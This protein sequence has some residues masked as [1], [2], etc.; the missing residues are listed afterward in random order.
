M[1]SY[2]SIPYKR[3]NE[4]TRPKDTPSPYEQ[5]QRLLLHY[6]SIHTKAS[7]QS[8]TEVEVLKKNHK[9]IREEFDLGP[10]SSWEDRVAI[11]YYNQLF[12]E[13]CLGDFSRY[14]LKQIGLRWRTK[15]ECVAG[16]G[17]FRCGNIAC[18]I[19]SGLKSWEVLFKYKED[20][21]IKS[22]LVKIRTCEKCTKKLHYKNGK[23]R[24]RKGSDEIEPIRM[25][26]KPKNESKTKEGDVEDVVTRPEASDEELNDS[27]WS[28]PIPEVEE[29]TIEE[30]M[31]SFLAEMFL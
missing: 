24:K 6:S 14:K 15:S 23:D 21:E 11:K 19:A 31:D 29:K 8:Q 13:Y 22:E 28:K 7:T 9:F 30:E 4:V 2:F 26:K 20:G 5:H 1:S 12:K 27:V 18:D 25:E 17:Q 3:N 16:K 10:E